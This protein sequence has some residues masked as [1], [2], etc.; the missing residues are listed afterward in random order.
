LT[1]SGD[2]NAWTATFSGSVSAVNLSVSSTT[3]ATT[4]SGAIST[5]AL[6]VNGGVGIQENLIVLDETNLYD[7]LTVY[8]D[9]ILDYIPLSGTTT[10]WKLFNTNNIF[11]L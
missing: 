6:K 11:T 10:S 3:T 1:L 8:K 2:T 4:S 9:I 5:G 7:I